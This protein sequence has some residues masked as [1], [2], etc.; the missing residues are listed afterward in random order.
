MS[1]YPYSERFEVHR[2]LPEQGRDRKLVLD[3][4]RQIATEEDASWE[5][6]QISGSYYCG[7]HEHYDYVSEAFGLF[8]HV[9]ALL[10]Q[11]VTFLEK[12]G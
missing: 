9:N 1:D 12:R 8:G 3:E 10:L 7:D 5:T 4:L 11:I 2:S 6:G